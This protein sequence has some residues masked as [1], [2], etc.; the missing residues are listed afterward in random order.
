MTKHNKHALRVAV[1]GGGC[2]GFSYT[3]D[4]AE[5]PEEDDLVIE[6]DGATVLVDSVSLD[7]L[8][9]RGPVKKSGLDIHLKPVLDRDALLI[10]DGNPAYRAFCQATGISY[11]MVNL[12]KGQR[13]NG[14]YHLQNVNAYHSRFKQWLIRFHGIATKYLSNYLGWRRS[15]EQHP[16]I[17][18]ESLL[19]IALGQFPHLIRT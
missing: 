11:E 15:I 9:G 7:F 8:T 17:A 6:R 13:V 18:A 10:S 19:N 16:N 4:F 3:F 5:A 2:S 12:S 1:V 14:A